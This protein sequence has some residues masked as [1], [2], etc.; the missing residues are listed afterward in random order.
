MISTVEVSHFKCFAK[1]RLPFR[2]LT[3]LTGFNGGGKSSALQPVLFL[4]Q[5][6]R[7]N[8]KGD[9][10]SLN[11][12]LVELG[13]AG[14]VIHSMAENRTIDISVETEN[15]NVAAWGLFASPSHR[16]LTLKSRPPDSSEIERLLRRI[17]FISA[18][19][20]GASDAFPM[21]NSIVEDSI[22]VGRDGRFAPYWY[23]QKSDFEVTEGRRISSEAAPSFR[24]QFDSWLGSLFPGAQVNVQQLTQ[25]SKLCLQFR[26]SD[27]GNWKRPANVGY[28]LTYSFP[29][30]VALLAAST[31]QTIFIDSPE[32]H[33]H[34]AAQSEM[35]RVLAS[36]A[37]A[38]L[39]I[40]VETHSDHLLNGIRVAIKD[41]ILAPSDVAVHFFQGASDKD[42]GVLSLSIDENG[43]VSNWPN[44]FF[45]QGE[46][47][48]SILSDWGK[49]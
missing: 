46:R 21:P 38:G 41:G 32:A 14:E 29:I 7:G 5:S 2:K 13:T 33:L 42:H 4:S 34:P 6:L 10:F 43:R 48:L 12:D 1:L 40:V 26:F 18:I 35:G 28:G 3:L 25:V 22:D 24:I 17:I 47:D 23:D 8:I 36:F 44:G 9:G 37:A 49:K 30:L 15:G 19:R 31:D 11:G 45:D 16:H 20:E 39:Q 27:T